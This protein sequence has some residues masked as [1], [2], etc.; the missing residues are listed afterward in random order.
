[1]G[2]SAPHIQS[3]VHRHRS[4][5]RGLVVVLILAVVIALVGVSRMEALLRDL[6]SLSILRQVGIGIGLF[7]LILIPLTGIYSV[8]SQYAFWEGWLEGIPQPAE[9]LQA[10]ARH[11]GGQQVRRFVIYL[12]GIHQ[13]EKDHPPR[14]S[15]FLEELKQRLADDHRL[16]R[17]LET[18]TFLPVALA[19]DSGSAWFWRRLFHWQEH[20]PNGFVQLLAAVLVQANN[21]IKVGISSDRRYG[22][23]R[24]YELALKITLRLAEEGFDPS[25]GS[26]LVLLGYSGGGEMAMGVADYLRS[27]CKVPVQIIT[28][29][30]VFSGNQR[31]ERTKQVTLVVGTRDPV[32]AFGRIA[33][34]GR[35]PL[36]PFSKWNKVRRQGLVHREVIDGMNHNGNRG[37]FSERYRGEVV[38]RVLDVLRQTEGAR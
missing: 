25:Q 19:D 6:V 23:I 38:G 21:V 30:G 24:N 7:C 36:L 11:Q 17:D 13:Q 26:E 28:F 34:P 14:V 31:L 22:P 4:N 18:Y 15:A 5:W 8:V 3:Q 29:C 33:Y 2:T 1:M 12:D 32:A 16:V 20:H 9:L 27:I 10:N 37:P 35:L